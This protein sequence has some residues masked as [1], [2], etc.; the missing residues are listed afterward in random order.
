VLTQS[1]A[2]IPQTLTPARPVRVEAL[3]RTH[4]A[5]VCVL[6]PIHNEEMVVARAVD[7]VVAFAE[8][9][10][11]FSFVFVDDASTDG[12]AGV[13]HQRL[14]AGKERWG[15]SSE[16]AHHVRMRSLMR[17][18]GKCG[19]IRAAMKRADAEFVC[20]LD[21]DLAYS[22]DH[23]IPLVA[24]LETHDVAIG[25]RSLVATSEAR[26]GLLRRMLGETFNRLARVIL[27]LPYRDTQAGLK[28]F[29]AAAAK[30]LFAAQRLRSFAFDAEILYLAK[31]FGM[32]VG[33]VPARVSP[34]HASVPSSVNL[35]LD[36]IRMLGAIIGVRVND[37]RGR[38]R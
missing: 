30:R 9:H 21:G 10:P 33:E 29:R 15:R 2:A 20:F 34:E 5:R 35:I 3:S 16:L 28:G 36:P 12:T 25:S 6:L 18:R 17:N 24:A 19:A 14:A 31:K 8:Q 26:P 38:Y 1:G 11:D 32:K 27:G 23:L 7:E 13:A 22:L 37:W 4:R